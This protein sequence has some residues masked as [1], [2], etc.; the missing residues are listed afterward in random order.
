M[1]AIESSSSNRPNRFW[2]I[3][4]A[5]VSLLLATF[6]ISCGGEMTV[7]S[8][9]LA[10]Q[11][12]ASYEEQTGVEMKSITCEEVSPAEVGSEIRCEA[13]NASEADILIEGKVTAVNESDEKVDFDWEVASVEVPGAHYAEAAKKVLEEQ[14]G[15]P[16]SAIECPDRV[17]LETDGEFRCELTATD[18]STLGA[19]VTM[20]DDKGGF[21]IKVDE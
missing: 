4:L 16:L 11:V 2:S 21:D 12:E 20:T 7:S 3:S 5:A 9:E 19:T 8:E 1:S 15:S 14:T 18:G 6:A 10:K 13:T 17:K